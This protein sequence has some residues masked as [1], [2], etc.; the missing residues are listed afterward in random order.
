[1]ASRKSNK[2][3]L[4]SPES[5]R[6]VC[7]LVTP[8]GAPESEIRRRV[9]QWEELVYAP[10][11]SSE[12]ELVRADKISSPGI[13]TEQILE[14]LISADLVVIDFTGLNP[15]VMYE[16]AVRHIARLPYI[17]I[18]PRGMS[19]PFDI[20]NI[21]SIEYDPDDLTYPDKLRLALIEAFGAVTSAKYSVPEILKYKFD[22][23]TIFDDPKKF[24]DLL[25]DKIGIG[26]SYIKSPGKGKIVEVLSSPFDS[27]IFME[28]TC[29]K[30]G[31]V[32]DASSFLMSPSLGGMVHTGRY[33]CEVCGTE[34]EPKS[35]GIGW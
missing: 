29:P 13:I 20:H 23:E 33:R 9:D 30:C 31:V 2:L 11:L 10:A 5:D 6:K 15:N 18:H 26:S 16:A 19:I 3:R 1:M 22:L 12:Y 34:F 25:A 24:V 4:A 7:F 14:M 21:R 8:I 35:K 17:H 32:S 28:V 27:S